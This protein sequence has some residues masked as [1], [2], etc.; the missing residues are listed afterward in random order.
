VE[1]AAKATGLSEKQYQAQK[2]RFDAG[3][4]TSRLVLQAQDDLETARFN[5]LAAKVALRNALAQLHR[6]EPAR[7]SASRSICPEAGPAAER[8]SPAEAAERFIAACLSH[9]PSGWFL[10]SWFA[11]AVLAGQQQAL[12]RLPASATLAFSVLGLTA[13]PFYADSHRRPASVG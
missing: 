6:L 12:Q 10:G 2:A 1:I 13:L 5:E 11:T 8:F 3:L 4:S 9:S 7:C